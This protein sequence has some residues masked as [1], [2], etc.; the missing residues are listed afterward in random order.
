ME[1][2]TITLPVHNG[3]PYLKDAVESVLSQTYANFRFFIIDDGSTDGS[4]EYLRSVK[5]PRI[6]LIVRENRGLGNTLNQLFAQ[7]E[8]EY[9][10]RMDADDVC[11][12]HRVKTIM[13]FLEHNQDVVMVGSDQAFLV[14]SRTLNA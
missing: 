7:S 9:V 4:A 14:G 11:A 8:T 3:M 6:R 13:A 1:N 12:P 2:L 5:D 10:A